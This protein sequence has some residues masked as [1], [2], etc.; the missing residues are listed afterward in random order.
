MSNV[1]RV[2]A[3]EQLL[4]IGTAVEQAVAGTVI[5]GSAIAVSTNSDY[6]EICVKG[7]AVRYT[8]DGT[9]PV[10]AAA[11]AILGT[12][13]V[14]RRYEW[15]LQARFIESTGSAPATLRVQGLSS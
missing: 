14:I 6:V 10:S 9:A 1:I 5:L 13:T 12:G 7:Q 4:A 2:N 11:G 8:L 3:A 15:L